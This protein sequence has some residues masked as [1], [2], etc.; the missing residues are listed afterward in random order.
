MPRNPRPQIEIS[1][2]QQQIIKE[3]RDIV[4]KDGYDKLTMRKLG[5]RLGIA[6]KTIYNYYSSKEEIY[7]KIRMDGFSK[8]YNCLQLEAEKANTPL[9]KLHRISHA[10]VNFGIANRNY[11]D[12]MFTFFTPKARDFLGSELEEEAMVELAQAFEVRD[13]ILNLFSELS[14]EY[15]VFQNG[16]LLQKVM[17]WVTAVH[18]VVSLYNS[19]ILSYLDDKPEDAIENLVHLHLYGVVGVKLSESLHKF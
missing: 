2:I 8:L 11:Y 18:G 5:S 10:W 17:Q 14:S 7:I 15:S 3:A 4:V 19:T 16:N 6:A 1:K 13:L 9:Q 12:I